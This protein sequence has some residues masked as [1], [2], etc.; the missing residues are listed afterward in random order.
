MYRSSGT[1]H[2][3]LTQGTVTC[4]GSTCFC[5]S[6]LRT[7]RRFPGGAE[8]D[9]DYTARA[10]SRL[11]KVDK[12]VRDYTEGAL[13]S[14]TIVREKKRERGGG[15]VIEGVGGGRGRK[16]GG[17]E[18]GFRRERPSTRVFYYPWWRDTY[19]N[20]C[21]LALGYVRQRD[22]GA[23]VGA[24]KGVPSTLSVWERAGRKAWGEVNGK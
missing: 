8:W 1:A 9:A 22:Q 7:A 13:G 4:A 14:T 18:R 17:M 20:Y 11:A 3:D 24:V 12:P 19:C 23:W 21:I 2:I 6:K 5:C 10:L 15:R 16:G